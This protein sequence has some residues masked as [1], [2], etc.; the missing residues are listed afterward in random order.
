[1]TAAEAMESTTGN[2]SKDP[3]SESDTRPKDHHAP[4]AEDAHTTPKKRRKVN[5]ACLYCRRSERPCTRCIKRNIGHLCHDEPREHE[6]KKPKS[7]M[8]SS[9]HDSETQSDLGRST[10]DRS[11]HSMRPPSFDSGLG[12]PSGQAPKPAFDTAALGRGTP[13]QLVQPTP[14]SGI[15]ASALSGAMGQCTS[16]DPPTASYAQEL[17]LPSPVPGFSDVWMNTQNHYHDMHNYHPNFVA[18]SEVTN[19]FNLLNEFLHSTLL[20]GASLPDG[21]NQLLGQS[22]IDSIPSFHNNILL[23]PSATQGGS[24]P[25][26]NAEQAK[27]IERP[28]SALPTDKAREY[29]LQAA[30]PAGNDAPDERMERVLKAK[31]DAG[32]LKPF[33]YIKGYARLSSY[34]DTHVHPSSKQKIL[35]QLDRFRPKF[36]EKMQALT[37]MD[38]VLVEMWFERTLM[39][40]DRVFASMA[41]PACCWRRTGEI[42]RGNKEMAE[43]INVPVESLR[44]G[45]IALHEILTEESNVRYWE[46]F[47]TIAFD[48]AHDTLLTACSLKSPDDKS[49]RPVMKCC[50]SFRIRRDDHK[51][52]DYFL[53]PVVDCSGPVLIFAVRLVDEI[54]K[55][56][57]K[58]HACHQKYIPGIS[59]DPEIDK[60]GIQL[61]NLCTRLRR[62]CD[63][64]AKRLRRLYLFA[65]VLSFHLLAVSRSLENSRAQSMIHMLKLALKAARECIDCSVPALATPMLSKAADYKGRLQDLAPRLPKDEVDECNRLEVEYYIVRTA[66]S[67][68]ENRLDVAEHMYTKAGRLHEVLTPDYAE[69]LADVLY[70]IGKS[71]IAQSDFTLAVKWLERANETINDQSLDI[72]S[73]EGIE[74][75]LAILQ[76]MVTALLGVGTPDALEKA[77]RF[78]GCIET[79]VGNKLVVS[80]LRLELLHKTPAEVFDSDAYADVLRRIIRNFNSTDSAFKLIMHHI[81]KLHDK[82]PG[83]GC[84][85]LDEF[86]RALVGEESPDWMERSVV[87]RMWMVINQRD[88]IETINGARGVLSLVSRPLTAEA[89]TA[90]L[91]LIW[92]KLQSNYA[93]GQFDLAENWCLLCLHGVFTNCGP[94]NKS[95]LESMET[96]VSVIQKMSKQSWN[97]PMTGYL[98]FKVAIRTEDRALAEQC[99]VEISTSPDHIDYL[100]ACIAESQKAGDIFCAIAALK[101]VQEK[102]EFKEPNSIHLPALFRCTIRLLHILVDRPDAR[103]N[104]IIEELCVAFEAVLYSTL[105]KIINEIW[106]LESFDAVKMA[107]Y[108]RCLFQATLPLD[109][110]LAMKLLDEACSKARELRG[111]QAS[112]PEEELEWM[113]TTAFNHAIDYYSARE[114]D[115][116]QQWATKA[117]N[118]SHYRDDEGS[119]ERLLQ[120]KFL[121]LNM[122]SISAN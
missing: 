102:Y 24:M 70:E 61:W 96:A 115:L 94:N 80:L 17:R 16:F 71:L 65:R 18:P 68:A 87:T 104:G 43:L 73:R 60:Q 21:Q 6:T 111:A 5:H 1:M 79:E 106:V 31:Y 89:T 30:D 38:L 77:G 84:T 37:D 118:L 66:V 9:V 44:G 64:A 91:A 3:K 2:E 122:G 46:E 72:L 50:F 54:G 20:E 92:K 101:K 100:G 112:W 107:K 48:P 109:D 88:S 42:F 76:A 14:V 28:T 86:I 7:A 36:R 116:A 12:N 82:S 10:V 22:Q 83:A 114:N 75:R 62:E 8:A 39:E 41:V 95:K 19:E 74:L 67:W 81:R 105:R 117:I 56:I 47:G 110:A 103:E 33:S 97:E 78:V 15:Q 55:H 32:L 90:A 4:T 27:S 45:K 98:A 23:P 25:P 53:V 13:L 51:M 40:Y 121:R 34:L 29:Y 113:A 59:G 58:L 69:R 85:V 63:T 93:L 57:E 108:T 119:L 52:Y 11:V 120:E 35:R 49:K 99:L 26:P